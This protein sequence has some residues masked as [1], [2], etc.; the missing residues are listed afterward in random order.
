[1]IA[2]VN[3]ILYECIFELLFFNHQKNTLETEI[4]T[5]SVLADEEFLP[6]RENTFDLVVSSLR[7]VNPFELF[8]TVCYKQIIYA[9]KI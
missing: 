2:L 7:L 4:P 5:I 3:D 8:K 9:I 6:F 1:M